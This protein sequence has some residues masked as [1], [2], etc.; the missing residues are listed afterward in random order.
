MLDY[1]IVKDEKAGRMKDYVNYNLWRFFK[2]N[3]P[4][5]LTT[6]RLCGMLMMLGNP[7]EAD[8]GNG[9]ASREP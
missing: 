6:D 1:G 7:T 4:N 8:G 2:N 9:N 5:H 3:V